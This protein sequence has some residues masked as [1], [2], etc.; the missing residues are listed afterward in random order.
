MKSRVPKILFIIS[1]IL[2]VA[3][4]CF[5]AIVLVS[6]IANPS[7]GDTEEAGKVLGLALMLVM[8]LIF[9]SIGFGICTILNIISFAINRNLPEYPKQKKWNTIY[10]VF[11]F[12]PFVLEV[13]LFASFR[14]ALA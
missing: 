13:I 14:I 12:V 2:T 9:G 1:C 4:F 11:I 6:G 5:F 10:L 3:C 7:E 8:L